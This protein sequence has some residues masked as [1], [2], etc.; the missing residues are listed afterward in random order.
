MNELTE[1]RMIEAK[2]FGSHPV[3]NP[4]CS[5]N[6]QSPF[7]ATSASSAWDPVKIILK[8]KSAVGVGR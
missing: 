8:R 5:G 2:G 7:R 3:S 1:C 4:S 6:S